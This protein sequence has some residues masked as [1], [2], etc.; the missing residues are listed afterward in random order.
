[1]SCEGASLWAMGCEQRVASS[2]TL[3]G[4]KHPIESIIFM[5]PILSLRSR[6]RLTA[7]FRMT[8]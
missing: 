3:E 2:V 7:P 4:V 5:D 1:M 6:T 8:E